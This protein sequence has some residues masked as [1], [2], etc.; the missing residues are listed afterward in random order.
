MRIVCIMNSV[1][2]L[3]DFGRLLYNIENIL[4]IITDLCLYLK[5]C[6]NHVTYVC[7]IFYLTNYVDDNLF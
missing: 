6:L 1:M 7:S 2:M 3:C 4:M 5:K